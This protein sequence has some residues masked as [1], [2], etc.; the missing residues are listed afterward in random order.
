MEQARYGGRVT[1]PWMAQVSGRLIET[2]RVQASALG[3]RHLFSLAGPDIS[4]AGPRPCVSSRVL[5]AVASRS[6]F[7]LTVARRA[8]DSEPVSGLPARP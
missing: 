8:G 4:D 7:G 2:K 3:E 1:I 5:G 6:R